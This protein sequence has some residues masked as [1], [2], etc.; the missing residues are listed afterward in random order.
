MSFCSSRIHA[1]LWHGPAVAIPRQGSFGVVQGREFF[2]P[3]GARSLLKHAVE[4]ALHLIEIAR[5]DESARDLGLTVDDEIDLAA[6]A[7]LTTSVIVL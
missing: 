4:A 3:I 6:R 2:V 7:P 5:H 1:Q